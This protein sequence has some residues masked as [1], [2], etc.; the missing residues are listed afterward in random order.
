MRLLLILL[1]GTFS[2]S[3]A[4]DKEKDAIEVPPKARFEPFAYLIGQW[5]GQGSGQP[6]VSSVTHTYEYILDSAFVRF[7]TESIYKPQ[8]KNPKGEVHRS[9]GVIGYDETSR[10][11]IAYIF[12]NESFVEEDTIG[13]SADSTEFYILSSRLV[14]IPEGWRSK[15]TF[16]KTSSDTH[17]QIFELAPPGKEFKHFVTNRMEKIR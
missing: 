9:L 8:E 12:H 5:Q 13:F 14:N 10:K 7:E 6:G 11:F 2:F 15:L 4:Q 1:L 17:E 3:V 16:R